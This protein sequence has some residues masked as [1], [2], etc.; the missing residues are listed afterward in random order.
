MKFW[1]VT[2][3]II[4]FISGSVALLHLQKS[5]SSRIGLLYSQTGTMASE[6]KVIAEMVRMAVEEINDEGG[7]LNKKI[8]IVEYDGRSD[9]EEFAKGASALISGG[10]TTII[11]CW[12]SASR[13][14]VKPV[15]EE[16]GGL[17]FYPV[18][19]EGGEDS[20]HIIYLGLSANQ[21]INPTI[22][23]I[24]KHYGNTVYLVG[25]DY[26]YPRMADLYIKAMAGFMG[27]RVAGSAY[28]PLG[29]TDFSGVI[30]Q[31]RRSKPDAIINTINGSSN[32]AFFKALR[33]ANITAQEIPVFSLSVDQ[34]SVQAIASAIGNDPL[35]GHYAT[36]S[37]FDTINHP[38]NTVFNE[39]LRHRF[40]PDYRAT[41]AGYKAY[42]AVQF[43]KNA[44]LNAKTTDTEIL[45]SNIKRES[46][47]SVVGIVYIDPQNNHLSQT[48]R[49]AAIG[50]RGF[51]VR[52]SSEHPVLPHPYPSIK[53][54][55]FWEQSPLELYR[56]WNNRWERPQ[57]RQ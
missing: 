2:A 37:Y 34:S 24:K 20:E 23:Y 43:W 19:Y 12:T 35:I 44:V 57:E 51:E 54:R 8:E 47:D 31:I 48:V 11:G 28:L 17:L 5:E 6:E 9:P 36:W 14:A 10:A 3:F 55:E 22:S 13:K 26:I 33:D 49:I 56:S 46:M 39:K 38:A 21:Q 45:R 16:K 1:F 52:W 15:L 4:A 32:I 40:G 41:D 30:E 25:S 18:Q 42:M 27:I 7:L 50:P 29:S 53:S